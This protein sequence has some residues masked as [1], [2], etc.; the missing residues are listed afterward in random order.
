MKLDVELEPHEYFFFW[1]VK[2]I[3]IIFLSPEILAFN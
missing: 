2:E 3:I 1:E